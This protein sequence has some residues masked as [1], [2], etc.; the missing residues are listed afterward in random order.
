MY[1]TKG[2]SLVL[3]NWRRKL[4]CN[5]TARNAHEMSSPQYACNNKPKPRASLTSKYCGKYARKKMIICVFSIIHMNKTDLFLIG[6]N[7]TDHSFTSFHSPW[8]WTSYHIV[9]WNQSQFTSIK[10]DHAFHCSA[11]HTHTCAHTHT[12]THIK[13]KR[14]GAPNFTFLFQ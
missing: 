5:F 1:P 11:P 7:K 3:P 12:H 6:M 10:K 13:Y 4:C 8:V 9:Y 2:E 14:E